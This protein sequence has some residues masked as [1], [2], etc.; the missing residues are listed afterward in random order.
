MV[1]FILSLSIF[2]AFISILKFYSKYILVKI[3]QHK[4]HY[5]HRRRIKCLSVEDQ[6]NYGVPV[7]WNIMNSLKMG[8]LY[9]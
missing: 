4:D 5:K 9:K 1:N 7:F 8:Y 3:K 6:M 2:F